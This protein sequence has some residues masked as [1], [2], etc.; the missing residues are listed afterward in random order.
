M[1]TTYHIAATVEG[2]LDEVTTAAPATPAAPTLDE[3]L[4]TLGG[5]AFI[6]ETVAHLQGK[7][8]ELLPTADKARR[9]IDFFRSTKPVTLGERLMPGCT[10]GAS[11]ESNRCRCD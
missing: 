3:L 10:C 4:D 8:R 1:R 9:M 5:L 2:T 6:V 11:P 7:E